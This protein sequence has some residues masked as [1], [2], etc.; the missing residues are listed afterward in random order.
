MFH[1]AKTFPHFPPG[2]RLRDSRSPSQRIFFRDYYKIENQC[3]HIY[4]TLCY[5][6]SSNHMR[7]EM[8]PYSLLSCGVVV[9]CYTLY[10]YL[11]VC[12]LFSSRPWDQGCANL[13]PEYS[14][15]SIWRRHIEKTRGPWGQGWVAPRPIWSWLLKIRIALCTG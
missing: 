3:Y 11:L 13:I 5:A 4:S 6:V 14:R 12:R 7:R 8:S 2:K 9:Y 10:V 15:F 1:Q